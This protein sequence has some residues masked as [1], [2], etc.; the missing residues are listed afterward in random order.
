MDILDILLK[1]PQPFIGVFLSILSSEASITE[2]SPSCGSFSPLPLLSA[3]SP[4][5]RSL[6]SGCISVSSPSN[7]GATRELLGD[8]FWSVA[9]MKR[10]PWGR[11]VDENA[12]EQLELPCPQPEGVGG[13]ES[14]LCIPGLKG[15]SSSSSSLEEAGLK[16]AENE[17]T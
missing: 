7:E 10:P 14:N 4:A 15:L 5:S 13:P 11:G 17:E 6:S 2:L 3:S 16:V 8:S 12:G 1:P 9:R